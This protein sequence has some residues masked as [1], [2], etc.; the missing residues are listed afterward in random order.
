MAC[1]P[2]AVG[3]CWHHVGEHKH[4]VPVQL[5]VGAVPKI[6]RRMQSS[7]TRVSSWTTALPWGISGKAESQRPRGLWAVGRDWRTG[8]KPCPD[9]ISVA[10]VGFCTSDVVCCINRLL[11]LP[12]S[13]QRVFR[14]RS[15]VLLFWKAWVS[16]TYW[17][18]AAEILKIL[19]FLEKQWEIKDRGVFIL[20]YSV[21]MFNAIHSKRVCI[22]V[23]K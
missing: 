11:N 19:K 1:W 7:H 16:S 6:S 15:S 8:R 3:A 13:I 2:A 14:P 4:S 9:S 22:S 5:L 21:I 10:Q 18:L 23:C 12:A 20:C 17:K